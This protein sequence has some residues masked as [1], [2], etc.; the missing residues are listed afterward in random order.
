MNGMSEQ[1]TCHERRELGRAVSLAAR[2]FFLFFGS[3]SAF[4]ELEGNIYD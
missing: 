2:P 4:D 3:L 1:T